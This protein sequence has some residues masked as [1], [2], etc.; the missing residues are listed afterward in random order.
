M[1]GL[2]ERVLGYLREHPGAG[3][4][5]IA[6]AIG[7]PV[8]RVRA[9]LARL[10]DRGL[11]ARGDEGRYY[12]VAPQVRGP[13]P[14]E[15]RRRGVYVQAG[16]VEALWAELG[17]LRRRLEALEERLRRLEERCGGGEG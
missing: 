14:L 5:E 16:D 9:A 13:V 15:L 4:R 11:V 1:G 3:P 8:Q 10:R 2:E 6:D 7:E 17:R 12:A